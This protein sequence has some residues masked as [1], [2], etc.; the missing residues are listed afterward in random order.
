LSSRCAV[1][2]LC[3][4]L[5]FVGSA[6]GG[7]C[8]YTGRDMKSAHAGFQLVEEEF[9]ALV[10]DLVGALD[11]FKV[12][13]KEK[14]EILAAL[15]PLAKDIVNPPPAEAAQ[16][17]AGLAKKALDKAAELRTRGNGDAH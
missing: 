7:R 4:T 5:E 13:K 12:P 3:L 10:E 2:R 8:Q 11:Q 6:P 15:G 14:D 1:P 9:N 16:H 17:D